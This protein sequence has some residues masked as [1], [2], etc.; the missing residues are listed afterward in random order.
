[1]KEKTLKRS[2]TDVLSNWYYASLDMNDKVQEID[3]LINYLNE[4]KQK[5]NTHIDGDFRGFKYLSK[6][7]ELYE[8]IENEHKKHNQILIELGKELEQIKIEHDKNNK[9]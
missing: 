9:L 1:M 4:L 2:Y 8:R 3:V 6:I 7:E 5:G